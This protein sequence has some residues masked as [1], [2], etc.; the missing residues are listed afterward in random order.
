MN[1]PH[2]DRS[3]P[4]KKDAGERKSEINLTNDKFNA[5]AGKRK[6]RGKL[7]SRILL[8]SLVSFPRFCCYFPS[9]LQVMTTCDCNSI[10]FFRLFHFPSTTAHFVAFLLRSDLAHLSG[11][12]LYID[13]SYKLSEQQLLFS[14]FQLRFSSPQ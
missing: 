5:D 14:A 6:K 8:Q 10:A 1:V 4:V 12:P 3:E 7:C 9:F 13:W 11:L 2:F